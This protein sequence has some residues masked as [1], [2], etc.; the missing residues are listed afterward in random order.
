MFIE[1]KKKL[2]F[3]LSIL[4]SSEFGLCPQTR[5]DKT[6]QDGIIYEFSMRER[7]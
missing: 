6:R 1:L 7:N 2:Q 4:Q 5:H 3:Q